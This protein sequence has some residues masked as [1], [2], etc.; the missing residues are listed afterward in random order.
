[1][2]ALDRVAK[3]ITTGEVLSVLLARESHAFPIALSQLCAVGEKTGNMEEMF[4]SIATYY[5]EEFD[6]VV[7]A[8]STI[9]EPLMIVLIGAIIGLL[10]VALYLPIFSV[11][12]AVG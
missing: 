12:S 11:G 8:L 10:I 9:I 6:A 2:Y 3:Q 4:E 7:G 5:E 1:M